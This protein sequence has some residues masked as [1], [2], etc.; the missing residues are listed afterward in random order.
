MVD[1]VCGTGRTHG[2][3]EDTGKEEGVGR[4]R[5]WGKCVS[6]VDVNRP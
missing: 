6:V 2:V 3:R 4:G 5:R 1:G